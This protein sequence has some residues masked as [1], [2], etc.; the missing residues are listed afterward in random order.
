MYDSFRAKHSQLIEMLNNLT[1]K[2]VNIHALLLCGTFMDQLNINESDNPGY[3]KY[4]NFRQNK[5]GGGVAVYVYS[6]LQNTHTNMD[7]EALG[8]SCMPSHCFV[9]F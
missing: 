9:L 6:D 8:V 2:G 3:D 4:V 1:G 5:G 7:T